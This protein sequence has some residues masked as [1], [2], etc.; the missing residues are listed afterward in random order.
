[1]AAAV[2]SATVR[3]VSYCRDDQW[4][5]HRLSVTARRQ[6]YQSAFSTFERRLDYVIREAIAVGNLRGTVNVVRGNAL[7]L[8]DV[9]T[10]AQLPTQYDVVL[11]SP[12][13]GDSRSTVQY[14]A[15]SS[16]SL[17][18]LKHL[19]HLR[20][21]SPRAAEI[22]GSCLGGKR[23]G[24]PRSARIKVSRYWSGGRSNSLRAAVI[25]F[26][27]DMQATCEGIAG[28]VKKGGSAVFVVARRK[29]GGRRVYLDKFIQ[30]TMRRL[31]FGLTRVWRRRI[32][33]K[34]TPSVIDRSA[35]CR[36][37]SRRGHRVQTMRDE[38]V[39]EFRNANGAD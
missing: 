15:M 23:L 12:P 26:L 13:Y 2:L 28:V 1:M 11:T 14:G 35:S 39:L 6:F 10:N 34:T 9:L 27:E 7:L 38:F 5:L 24:P 36:V 31:G 17:D 29:T 22:D 4:K 8:R 32:Q 30:R 37:K 3:D 16:L 21:Q 25:R 19:R 18:V 33:G 20:I